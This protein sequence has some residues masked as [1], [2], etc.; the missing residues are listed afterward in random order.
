MLVQVCHAPDPSIVTCLQGAAGQWQAGQNAA[1]GLLQKHSQWLNDFRGQIARFSG[2]TAAGSQAAVA[3]PA[4]GPSCGS[5]TQQPSSNG[6]LPT[7]GSGA[8]QGVAPLSAAALLSLQP[9]TPPANSTTVA[10]VPLLPVASLSCIGSEVG[11]GEQPGAPVRL[12]L[13]GNQELLISLVTR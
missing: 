5:L 11:L 3:G 7:P 4:A 13:G 6:S 10:G 12:D 9:A 2:C 1:A 8:M